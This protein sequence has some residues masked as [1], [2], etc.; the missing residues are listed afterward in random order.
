MYA[1]LE[2]GILNPKISLEDNYFIAEM[3]PGF[4]TNV[5]LKFIHFE[6]QKGLFDKNSIIV[7]TSGEFLFVP[8]DF[9]RI[10]ELLLECSLDS[11]RKKTA[12]VVDSKLA[13]SLSTTL[14]NIL[15]DLP[16]EQ[17]VFSSL[18]NA[19]RWIKE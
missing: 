19:K 2:F 16:F 7:V 5:I 11:K 14:I 9:E 3:P 13:Y 18:A 15:Q 8:K 1:R 17:K 12:I 6:F 4:D 10:K